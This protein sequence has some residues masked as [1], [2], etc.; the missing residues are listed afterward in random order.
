MLKKLI[1]KLSYNEVL[2]NVAKRLFKR[3]PK[4]RSKLIF[5]R[6]GIS[7]NSLHIESVSSSDGM[8]EAIKNDVELRRKGQRTT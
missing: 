7:I 6:N 4:I 5:M 2:N 8:I 3:F 1:I